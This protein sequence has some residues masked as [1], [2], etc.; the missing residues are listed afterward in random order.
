M[1]V[2]VYA[3]FVAAIYRLQIYLCVASIVSIFLP[4]DPN[5]INLSSF[6]SSIRR[7]SLV[8]IDFLQFIILSFPRFVSLLFPS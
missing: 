7:L 5:S 6:V 2:I 4:L 8:S 1:T 3:F